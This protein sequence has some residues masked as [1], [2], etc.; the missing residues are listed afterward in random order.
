M[1]RASRRLALAAPKS[2]RAYNRVRVKKDPYRF[3]LLSS[4]ITTVKEGI[5]V[6]LNV[7]GNRRYIRVFE[8]LAYLGAR[9]YTA[10]LL[11]VLRGYNLSLLEGPSCFSATAFYRE[12]VELLFRLSR[13]FKALRL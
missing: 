4:G 2:S 7:I 11:R 1:L 8:L 3:R 13:G 10:V 6:F 9:A 5:N 12:S